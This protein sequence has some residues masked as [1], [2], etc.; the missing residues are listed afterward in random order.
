MAIGLDGNIICELERKLP[1]RG[2]HCCFDM[3][4]ISKLISSDR[5]ENALK[6]R[7]FN[8]DLN[9]L[10][11]NVRMLLRQSLKGMLAA[12]SR[13]GVLTFGKEAVFKKIK[14][15]KKGKPFVSRDLSSN[16]LM[17]LKR[18]SEE[19]YILPFTMDELGVFLNR[20]PIGVLFIDEP[21]LLDGIC[22]RL[23]QE[24]AVSDC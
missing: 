12:S 2:A 5:L 6:N 16:S 3:R 19:F 9:E 4:C 11:Q 15:T 8:F 22:L 23:I 17:N 20:K 7:N 14:F 13:K 1:G 18:V 24:R 10:V 21:L